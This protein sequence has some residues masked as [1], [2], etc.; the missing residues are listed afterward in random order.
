MARREFVLPEVAV[1]LFETTKTVRELNRVIGRVNR[2]GLEEEYLWRFYAG[3]SIDGGL[4]VNDLGEDCD[5]RI[6]GLSKEY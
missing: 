5:V 1:P 3:V 6:E 4:T 2:I